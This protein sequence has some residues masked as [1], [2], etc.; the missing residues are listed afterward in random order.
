MFK[1]N[2][3]ISRIQKRMF[4]LS[5]ITAFTSVFTQTLAVL[6]DNFIVC[7]FYGEAEIAAITLAGPFFYMLEIPAA[8]IASGIQTVCTKRIGAGEVEKANDLFNQIFFFLAIAMAVL[9]CLSF[10]LVPRMAVWFGARGNTA[11]LQP[12]TEQYLYGLSFE[13]LPYVLFC[14]MTPVVLLDNGGKLVTIASACGCVT[15]IV[16]DLCSVRFG[17]GLLG[18]GIASSVSAVVYF[19]ITL[20][21]FA[22]R[23][24]VLHL[25]FVRIRFSEVKGAIA[26]SFPKIALSFSDTL[27]SLLLI[28]L[29]SAI[30]SVV[31][32]C[33]LSIHGTITYTVM[34]IAKG[35]AGA[36]GIMNGICW[37]EKNGD[38]L[39]KNK[40]LAN[41][42]MLVAALCTIVTLV[43]LA[44][45]LSVALTDNKETEELLKFAIYCICVT[46]P[47]AILVQSRISYLQA[48]E[49]I[50]E[51]QLIGVMS[52]LILLASAAVLYII[53]FRINGLFMAF[54]TAYILTLIGSWLLHVKRTKRAI[55]SNA[56]YLEV[57]DSFFPSPGDIISYPLET[58][59]ECAL[60]SEQVVLF[61][62]GHKIEERK[63]FIAGVCVEELAINAFQHGFK[64]HKGIKTVDI[65]VTIDDE[66]V[67]ISLK[68]NGSA[69]N[70]KRFN[71]RLMDEDQRKKGIG[72]RILLNSAKSISYYR[73]FD[74]N[75]TIIRV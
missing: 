2:V 22:K 26:A 13:I 15:D 18:I 5:F 9:T 25:R 37:G 33:V 40:I 23:D 71:D 1:E 55:P 42:Y 69:F 68:D 6:I 57:D 64:K 21:H 74:M 58:L 17:F 45:P 63:G 44:G 62:R 7:A 66:D 34:I 53:P 67:I 3:Y 38:D 73:T 16:L 14:I 32:T 10:L 35:I 72:I 39:L 19:L 11:V 27:R 70:L 41:R 50:R 20:L 29:A 30:G 61:C 56:D 12:L 65:R 52:N 75:T 54:P 48:I 28:S 31:G 24:K 43:A 49:H 46:T 60:A 59:E 4:F 51:A 47:F 8:G 36:V